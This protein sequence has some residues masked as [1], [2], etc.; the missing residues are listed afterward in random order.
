MFSEVMPALLPD[1]GAGFR[2]ERY[3]EIS[4]QEIGVEN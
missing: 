2:T 4:R 3:R 1:H